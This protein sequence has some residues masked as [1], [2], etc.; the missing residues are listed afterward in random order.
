MGGRSGYAA[1]LQPFLVCLGVCLKV[2][3]HTGTA[4]HRQERLIGGGVD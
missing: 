2:D 3:P 4:S 1:F